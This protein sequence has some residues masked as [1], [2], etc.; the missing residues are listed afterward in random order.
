MAK[1]ETFNSIQQVDKAGFLKKLLIIIVVVAVSVLVGVVFKTLVSGKEPTSKT[2]EAPAP[3]VVPASIRYYDPSTEST[4]ETGTNY[5]MLNRSDDTRIRVNAD[6]SVVLVDK[7]G[8][9]IRTLAGSE[10]EQALTTAMKIIE[11]DSL[12]GIALAGLEDLVDPPVTPEIKTPEDLAAEQRALAE[13]NTI[14][15]LEDQYGMTLDDFYGI[16]YKNDLTP[17]QYYNLVSNG[18][19]MEDLIKSTL[20]TRK[21]D[22]SQQS[23]APSS[24][25]TSVEGMTL[26]QDAAD[27]EIEYP[28]WMQMPDYSSGI[29]AMLGSLGSAVSASTS[30]ETSNPRTD[31]WNAVNDQSGKQSWLAEQQSRPVT[32]NKID[33]W[34]LVAGTIVPITIVT[35]INTDM[36]GDVVGLVRQN[37]YDTLT[38]SRILIPK[39]TRLMATYNSSVT[40]GQK[41]VQVAWNQMITPDGYVFTFPGF[42]S[43]TGEGYSG[44]SDKYNNH[45]WS[46]LGGAML[47]SIINYA[48]GEVKEQAESADAITGT[49]LISLLSGSVIDTTE[50][51]SE[52]FID[53]LID[54]QPTITI[55]PGHQTQLLVNQTIRL[56]RTI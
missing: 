37:V 33:E 54:R 46:I 3:S 20:D 27:D 11:S 53:R 24:M 16:L 42:Q 38:G 7:N 41:S 47:G 32:Q 43:V 45:F 39:G 26:Q 10:K 31:S 15:I 49:D 4:Y 48:T 2:P 56:E 35:G 6:G 21:S 12:A 18:M 8:A 55:R 9:V 51:V 13:S 29:E 19:N 34:D 40:W 50:T 52:R 44:D 14:T 30:S 17:A 23:G 5:I 1:K 22:D 36:P 28:S 25:S